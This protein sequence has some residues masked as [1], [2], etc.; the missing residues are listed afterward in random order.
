LDPDA[1]NYDLI[2]KLMIINKDMEWSV[3]H[4]RNKDS[5][6]KVMISGKERTKIKGVKLLK[7][8]SS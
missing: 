7:N 8:L 3:V 2:T 6:Y 4:G 5:G 1:L